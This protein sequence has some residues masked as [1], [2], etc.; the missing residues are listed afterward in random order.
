[1]KSYLAALLAVG[2]LAGGSAVRAQAAP[3]QETKG[4]ATQPMA[5]S[6][7][8]HN[9]MMAL[10][11]S[12]IRDAQSAARRAA[13]KRPNSKLVVRDATRSRDDLQKVAKHLQEA[14]SSV[15]PEM[16]E[17]VTKARGHEE[18]ALKHAEELVTAAQATPLDASAVKT[19]ADAVVEHAKAAEEVMK[20]HHEGLAKGAGMEKAKEPKKG[21]KK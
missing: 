21:P 7:K 6:E 10:Q 5:H 14:E 17:D 19:H 12:A 8:T 18:E 1:M 4:K 9:T 20:A 15:A 13:A 16:K 2:L 11:A 3:K